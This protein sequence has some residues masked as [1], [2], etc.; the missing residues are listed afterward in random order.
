M[1]S[2]DVYAGL[3]NG[4]DGYEGLIEAALAISGLL[5][6]DQQWKTVATALERAFPSYILTM[7]NQGDDATFKIF[8][9]VLRGLHQHILPLAGWSI[10]L[11]S[12]NCVG[13]CTNLCKIPCQNF[14]KDSLGTAVYMSPNFED[15]SCEMIFGQQ[16]PE[17][18]PALKQPCFRTK[19]KPALRYLDRCNQI[20][21]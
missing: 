13:M 1:D 5:S 15:M 4:K 2:M 21:S 16:P 3:K 9:G 20:S 10:F 18:D 8:S 6:V 12:T 7:A 11:E 17:D 14:I 19:C